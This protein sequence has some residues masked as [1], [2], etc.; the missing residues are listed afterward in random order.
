MVA[1]VGVVLPVER[2]L[3]ENPAI[4]QVGVAHLLMLIV[5]MLIMTLSVCLCVCSYISLL[6]LC[7]L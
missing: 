7:C 3:G 2:L 6:V 4:S 5:C 1:V